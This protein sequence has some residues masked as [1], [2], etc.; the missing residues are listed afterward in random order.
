MDVFAVTD[1]GEDPALPLLR[2]H[3]WVRADTSMSRASDQMEW[4][5]VEQDNAGM[6]TYPLT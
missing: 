4:T 5:S 3:S 6:P 2:L 1:A